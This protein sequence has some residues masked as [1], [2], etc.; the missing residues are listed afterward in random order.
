VVAGYGLTFAVFLITAGR[1]ADRHGRRA[2]LCAGM[3]LFVV[4]CAGMA[5]FVVACAACGCH[6][7]R[8]LVTATRF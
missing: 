5:L 2:V 1:L 3:A 8:N 6:P 7:G 4:A